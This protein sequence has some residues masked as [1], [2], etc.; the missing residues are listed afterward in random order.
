VT[1]L[2]QDAR[3]PT[4]RPVGFILSSLS[5][6]LFPL[7]TLASPLSSLFC[8]RSFLPVVCL[9]VLVLLLSQSPL[10]PTHQASRCSQRWWWWGVS[11][12]LAV[13]RGG[14]VNGGCRIGIGGSYLI[15]IPLHGPQTPSC[16]GLCSPW[17]F[18]SC[19]TT[20]HPV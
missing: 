14:A 12:S 16:C 17:L 20:S 4:V 2:A 7:I 6:P 5:C 10:P 3:D 9:P 15:C 19:L 8:R 11:G 1:S 13:P 18:E